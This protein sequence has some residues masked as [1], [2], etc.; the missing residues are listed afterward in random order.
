MGGKVVNDQVTRMCED[1]GKD[2][3]L[4]GLPICNRC[5]HEAAARSYGEM[6]KKAGESAEESATAV[7]T[8]N[9]FGEGQ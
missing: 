4:L 6:G 5:L 3:C 1:C 2:W 8:Q 7:D 9:T